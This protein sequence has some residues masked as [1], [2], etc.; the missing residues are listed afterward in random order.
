MGSI[1]SHFQKSPSYS[2]PGRQQKRDKRIEG[3]SA[4]DL[5]QCSMT[6]TRRFAPSVARF[7][8]GTSP[9]LAP[10]DG[11]GSPPIRP[12]ALP[13]YR[14]IH[15]QPPRNPEWEGI[16]TLPRGSRVRKG[17]VHR[18]LSWL[19]ISC[20]VFA[21]VVYSSPGARPRFSHCEVSCQGQWRPKSPLNPLLPCAMHGH[22]A[23]GNALLAS[24]ARA[25][26]IICYCWLSTPTWPGLEQGPRSL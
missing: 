15:A 3:L 18:L 23:L 7:G 17:T 12:T 16:R 25:G 19:L 11:A 8:V 14:R 9:L 26:L 10:D 6:S 21:V 20:I 13:P 1:C 5:Y 4:V 2:A 24:W 22:K